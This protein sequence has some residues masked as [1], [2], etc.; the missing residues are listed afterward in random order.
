MNAVGVEG[1]GE[2]V[3][4]GWF[5]HLILKNF[6]PICEIMNDSARKTLYREASRFITES[7]EK[8]AWDGSWYMRA[9]YDDG[10][11]LG[12]IQNTECMIASLPQSWSVISGGASPER[13]QMAMNAVDN[14]LVRK[15][16]GIILLF[17]PPFEKTEK[18]PGYIKSY[19]RG[20][21]ENGGQYTHAAVWVV[22]AFAELGD[23]N[24]A[25]ELFEMLNPINHSRSVFEANHYT[26]E[27]YV[28]AADIYNASHHTGRGGWTWYTGAAGWMYRIGC[29]NIL[30][31]RKE[32]DRLYVKPCIPMFWK[33]YSM[34]Y[35]FRNT[36]YKIDVQ[37]PGSLSTGKVHFLIDGEISKDDFIP[38]ENDGKTHNVIAVLK[39]D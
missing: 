21:R 11:P 3:W 39:K 29:E 20:L 19:A 16:K 9:F 38:L 4:L 1:K 34:E 12:S 17:S 25:Y 5:L 14:H 8:N 37:N 30:G 26:V 18:N 36:L 22:Q 13:A 2:S 27:P 33:K 15:E 24:K 32:G 10:S 7:I 6:V 35:A 28:V 23:G 31:L